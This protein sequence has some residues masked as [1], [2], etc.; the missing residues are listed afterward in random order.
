VV[1]RVTDT[2]WIT[3]AARAGETIEL[4]SIGCMLEVDTLYRDLP[5]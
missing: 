5:A 2:D 3:R 1:E 4:R